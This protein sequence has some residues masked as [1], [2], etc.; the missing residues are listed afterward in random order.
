MLLGQLALRLV[1]AISKSEYRKRIDSVVRLCEAS[2]RT[3]SQIMKHFGDLQSREII[4]IIER[5]EAEGSI[6][7]TEDGKRWQARD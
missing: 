5:A 4:E 2:P 6:R 7:K 3:R 1:E